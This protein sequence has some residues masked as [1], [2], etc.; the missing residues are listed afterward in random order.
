MH[1]SQLPQMLLALREETRWRLVVH[2]H[3]ERSAGRYLRMA[4]LDDTVELQ[5]NRYV[6]EREAYL[7][8]PAAVWRELEFEQMFDT[9]QRR[10]DVANV[11]PD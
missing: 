8:N 9:T 5:T 1:L 3:A 6:P 10:T 7:I 4:G 11:G 2:P